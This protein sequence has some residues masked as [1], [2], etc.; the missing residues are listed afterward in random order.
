MPEQEHVT[1]LV[2]SGPLHK[3][4]CSASLAVSVIILEATHG[5]EPVGTHRIGKSGHKEVRRAVAK[6]I[7]RHQGLS[8]TIAVVLE[9]IPGATAADSGGSRIDAIGVRTPPLAKL[10]PDTLQPLVLNLRQRLD[11]DVGR[12]AARH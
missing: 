2:S 3:S 10:E 1:R 7:G 6:S 4:T 9:L 8:A 11:V 12:Y 5:A